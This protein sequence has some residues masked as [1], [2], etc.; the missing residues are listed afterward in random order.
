MINTRKFV[1]LGDPALN[2]AFP[3]HNTIT[4][5]INNI[6]IFE[7]LDTLKA[8]SEVIISGEIQD[9]TEIN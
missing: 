5:E 3:E 7:S 2:F 8:L 4:S 1:L 9:F 6:S